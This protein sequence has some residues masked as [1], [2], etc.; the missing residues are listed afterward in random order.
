MKSP[1]RYCTP[2]NESENIFSVNEGKRC[3][4]LWYHSKKKHLFIFFCLFIISAKVFQRSYD[5]F[6]QTRTCSYKPKNMLQPMPGT[7]KMPQNL[8]LISSK[9][10]M[11][12]VSHWIGYMSYPRRRVSRTSFCTF[13]TFI[14][15]LVISLLHFLNVDY[16]ER[17]GASKKPGPFL[18]SPFLSYTAWPLI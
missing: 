1:S 18:L 4:T 11:F 10:Q 17:K 3:N 14:L 2:V 13:V 9:S 7:H 5:I 16:S 15:P 6:M 8:N 12:S